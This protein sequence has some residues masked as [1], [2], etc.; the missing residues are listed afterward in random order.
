MK[1]SESRQEGRRGRGAGDLLGAGSDEELG[2]WFET[3]SESLTNNG[4]GTSHIF[5]RRVSARA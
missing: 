2:L 3:V 1:H 5:I 4:V